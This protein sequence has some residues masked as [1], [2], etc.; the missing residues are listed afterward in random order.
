MRLTAGW[1]SGPVCLAAAEPISRD[2]TYGTLAPRL[3]ELGSRLLIRALDERPPFVEQDETGVTYA[4]KIGPED[5]P[6]HFRR[7]P[8]ENERAAR[9]P[10]PPVG[11]PLPLANGSFL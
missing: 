2:D 6:G 1:D 9:P 4:D 11:A 10:P 7:P 3:Q 8:M 5:R